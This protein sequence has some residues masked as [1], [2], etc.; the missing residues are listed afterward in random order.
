M[1]RRIPF[2]VMRGGTSR[3]LFFKEEDLPPAGPIR[4]RVILKAFGS[5]DPNGR[6][7]DGLGGATSTTSK[8]AVISRRPEVPNGVN[9]TFGQ[10]SID[11]H[12]VDRKGNCGNIS[13][14]VG[15]YAVDE[16]LVDAVEEPITTVRVYNTNTRKV[17]V[18]RVPVEDGR[19]KVEGDFGIAGI[20][21]TGALVELD[22]LDPGG[23]VTSGLL[24]TGKVV[25]RFSTPFGEFDTSIVDAANPLV[26][27]AA[28]DLGLTGVE[29]PARV[30]SDAELLAKIEAIRAAAAVEVGL[31]KSVETASSSPAV[32]KIAFVAAPVE[33]TCVNGTVVPAQDIDIICR[34]M[35]MGKL[36]N[37]YA[38]SGA[39][40]TAAAAKIEG[41]VVWN[42]V[43]PANRDASVVRLG[44][45]T[46][47]LPIDITMKL[48]AA[49]GFEVEKATAYRTARRLAEGFVFV[50][51]EYFRE[52][53]GIGG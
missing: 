28:A 21:G 40:C 15:P 24:P 17:I 13:S 3:A 19:H 16:G 10:V 25:N 33:Y 9:Y 18:S 41:S 52:D 44:H 22:F 11:K 27:V 34:I 20:P 23:A 50:P 38:I 31:A 35:S 47:V 6:Q 36:H 48:D 32:P 12:L 30:D 45:P 14:A 42:L 43:P 2:V 49:G 7:I 46:G 37:A 8:V 39:V 51:E 29:L 26:F 53:N 4:D 1:Q 5:P